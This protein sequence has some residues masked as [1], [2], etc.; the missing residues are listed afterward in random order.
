MP[1]VS[2]TE[3]ES[4]EK[5]QIPPK[6]HRRR[7]Q[8]NWLQSHKLSKL[9]DDLIV[10]ES[11]PGRTRVV[12]G[13]PRG[14]IFFRSPTLTACTSAALRP[15]E[16]HSTSLERSKPHPPTQSPSKRPEAPE[17]Q[18]FPRQSD[19]TSTVPCTRGTH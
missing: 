14:R 5:A 12:R 11:N 17:R 15:T 3:T 10:R 1:P 18:V 16:T 13:G 7:P 9:E 4:T 2:R 8:V 6:R 19:P